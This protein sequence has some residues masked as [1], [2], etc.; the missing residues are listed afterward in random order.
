MSH[1]SG[2]KESW[3]EDVDKNNLKYLQATKILFY[4]KS[5]LIK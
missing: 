2:F 3:N 1:P 5:T 4:K